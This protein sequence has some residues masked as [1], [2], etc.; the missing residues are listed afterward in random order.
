MPS[1]PQLVLIYRPRRSG[2]LSRP[3]CEV[4]HAEIRTR[5]LL[6]ENPA[7]Y[8]TATTAPNVMLFKF[9]IPRELIQERKEKCV[10]KFDCCHSRLMG[11][12]ELTLFS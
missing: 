12:S 2:R 7:L 9:S 1:Q 11:N 8:H 4:A 6:I 3:W 10:N 5:N